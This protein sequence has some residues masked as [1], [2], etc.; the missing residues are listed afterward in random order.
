MDVCKE[1]VVYVCT[2][3]FFG[4][5]ALFLAAGVVATIK[6]VQIILADRKMKKNL[7]MCTDYPY[8]PLEMVTKHFGWS[9][10]Y[11]KYHGWNYFIW[12]VGDD[13][14]KVSVNSYNDGSRVQA[15]EDCRKLEE[16]FYGVGG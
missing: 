4:I 11:E 12:Y 5:V 13:G 2:V 6:E 14:K 9:Y 3:L 16:H 10:E 8:L 15:I 7:K 1:I